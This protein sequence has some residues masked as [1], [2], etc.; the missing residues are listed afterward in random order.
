MNSA[1]GEEDRNEGDDG[2]DEREGIDR[3][4]GTEKGSD[5]ALDELDGEDEKKGACMLRV[6]DPVVTRG[7]EAGHMLMMLAL[8]ACWIAV[9]GERAMGNGAGSEAARAVVIGGVG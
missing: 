7:G 1:N 9:V 6:V 2:S 4:E 8:V 3:G 5:P